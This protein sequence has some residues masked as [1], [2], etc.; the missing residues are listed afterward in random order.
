MIN[1]SF[2]TS[3]KGLKLIK[4]EEGYRAK[5]YKDA[6]GVWTIGYGTTNPT[7]AFEGNEI[8][9]VKAETYLRQDVESA[10]DA[11][12]RFV[13]VELDQH[14]FDALVSFVYN[15]GEGAFRKSTLLKKLN[16]GDTLGAAN[17]FP[18]WVYAK[19]KKLNGLIKR[20]NKE[21]ALFLEGVVLPE[22]HPLESNISPEP[23]VDTP[24]TD[25]SVRV[26]AGVGGAGVL[27]KA[28]EQLEPLAY[29]SEY[30]MWA[31]IALSI[32]ALIYTW[33]KASKNE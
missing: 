22:K 28:A 24:S 3:P 15:V 19:G 33:G 30:I 7:V 13:K 23:V 6:V 21:R 12:R 9:K 32:G 27:A 2:H 1:N 5:A 29:Y 4:D 10:E 14:Q 16:S 18:R 8:G 26:A 17:E 31:F 11:I 20:R 25:R